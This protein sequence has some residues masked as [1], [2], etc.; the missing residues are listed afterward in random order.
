MQ[1]QQMAQYVDRH[2]QLRVALSPGAVI[3]RPRA[4]RDMTSV[5]QL[6]GELPSGLWRS[7]VGCQIC[8]VTRAIYKFHLRAEGINRRL[9]LWL[10]CP[11]V[12][13]KSTKYALRRIASITHLLLLALCEPP[14]RFQ[15]N[16]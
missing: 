16:V 12:A 11:F 14:M 8:R 9:R 6:N 1:R 13:L 4:T 15:T 3:A 5:N 2:A 10:A 7:P